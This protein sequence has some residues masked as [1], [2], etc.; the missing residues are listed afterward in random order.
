C[1]DLDWRASE[2]HYLRALELNPNSAT[3]HN[4][5]NFLLL[6]EARFDESL[7]QV[8][9][10]LELDPVTPLISLA[11]AWSY[12]HARRFDESLAVHRKLIESE[13]R[14]AYGRTVYSWTLR[15]AGLH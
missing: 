7:A 11:L 9:R 12:Y 15:C 13:P 8:T 14:F 3:A 2:E 4:W 1:R 6:Q 10:A 5:Y